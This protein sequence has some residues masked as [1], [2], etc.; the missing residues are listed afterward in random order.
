MNQRESRGIL[1]DVQNL[2][3][4]VKEAVNSDESKKLVKED[5]NKKV[6]VKK[7]RDIL[8]IIET[9]LNL[10]RAFQESKKKARGQRLEELVE[11]RTVACKKSKIQKESSV[12]SLSSKRNLRRL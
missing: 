9:E 3:C 1:V 12:G 8:T 2:E 5:Q 4:K 6:T 10:N 7:R 11:E